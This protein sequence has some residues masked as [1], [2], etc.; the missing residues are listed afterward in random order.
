M[1]K[2][3]NRL[4]SV[5]PTLLIPLVLFISLSESAR[6]QGGAVTPDCGP[7]QFNL[8]AAG[9]SAQFANTFPACDTWTVT[10]A[11]AGFSGLTLTFQSAAMGTA[12]G[13]GFPNGQPGSFSTYGGTIVAGVNPNTSTT[14]ATTQ[15]AN[16]AIASP[17]V[18]VN[19]SGLTGSGNVVGSFYGYKTGATG[20]NGGGGGSGCVGT[21][22]TPCVVDGPTSAGSPPTTPPVLQAGQDGTNVQTLK[23]DTNGSPIPSNA[24]SANADGIANTNTGPTGAAGVSLFQRGLLYRFNGATWDREFVCTNQASI[25]VTAATDAVI[26]SGVASTNI[27]VCHISFAG[28]ASTS[29]SINQGTGT[30]C[31]TNTA[32]LAGA[33]ANTVGLALDFTPEEALRTTVTGRDLCLH[34]SGTVTAGGTILYAQ[35]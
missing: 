21:V 25:T 6:G 17:F 28:N 27:R 18:R 20:G 29:V 32:T 1:I 22:A 13:A 10:Y 2:I 14:G 30:T 9:A 3:L 26:V 16:G 4:L 8:T 11:N 31:L 5:F 33:Y 23:V 19:L 12:P 7:I 15:F 34:F 35:Y 24:S